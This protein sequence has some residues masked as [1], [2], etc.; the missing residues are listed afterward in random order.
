MKI[1]E[2]KAMQTK[3]LESRLSE[4]R[5]ELVKLNA[6]VAMHTQIKNPG[7]IRRLKRNVAKMLTIIN[8]KKEVTSKI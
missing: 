1:K 8:Q 3:E 5:L 7:Q 6:Q 4:A 2:I